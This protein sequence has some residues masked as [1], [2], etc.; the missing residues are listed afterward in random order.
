MK[1]IAIIPAGGAGKR[2]GGCVPKQ[3]LSL[4]G[5]PILV[6]TLRVF[7]CSSLIDEI[8]LVVP[9]GDIPDVR[10]DL[11]QRYRISKVSLVLHGGRERQDS[12]RNA[13]A[14]LRDEHEGIVIHD[15]VRPFVTGDLIERAVAG[16]KE[17]GAVT[18]G[19]PIRDTVKAVDAAGG[20]VK[21]V[22]REGLWLTQTPQAFRREVIL[23][24]YARAEAD[25]FY[26]T[27][28]A[29]LVER[30]GIPVRMIR[31]DVDNIKVTMPEDLARGE[32]ILRRMGTPCR[33]VSPFT[34]GKTV[35]SKKY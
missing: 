19:V 9:E 4:A 5:I 23:A 18:V 31:G 10:R 16:A 20:V 30:M 32:M 7:Q 8:L 21:T 13:L 33:K 35:R 27:D 25:G 17:F 12:V 24:A 34:Q 26:G 11:V 3:Y 6:H 1:T 22:S 14:H 29:S 28:D 15:G 2:M